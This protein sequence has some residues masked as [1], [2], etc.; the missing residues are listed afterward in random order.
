[1]VA[2]LDQ[3]LRVLHACQLKGVSRH[4]DLH[5]GNVLVGEKDDADLD[6]SLHPREPIFVS[7]FGYGATGGKKPKDDYVGLADIVDSLFEKV[8]WD[9]ATTTDRQMIDG[10]RKLMDKLLRE[11]SHSERRSPLEILSSIKDLKDRVR[12]FGDAISFKEGG[13]GTT[14]PLSKMSVGQFQVSEMLGDDWEWWKKLFVSAVPA[15]SRI[16]EPYT[17]TV[18]T[19]PRGCGKTMLFRRLSARLMVECGPIDSGTVDSNF[20]GLY[21]NANDIADAFATFPDK[22]GRKSSEKLICYANLCIL[23]DVLAVQSARA[24][25]FGEKASEGLLEFLRECFFDAGASS[26]LIVGEDPLEHYRLRLEQIKW[27]FPKTTNALN[28]VGFDDLSRHVWFARF[29]AQARH[30][31]PWIGLRT[32]FLFIDDYTTPRITE[33]MQRVLN[34]MIF[35]RSSEFVSKV[36]TESATTFVPEDSSGKVLQDGDDYQLIDMG[37]EA[38]FMAEQERGWFLNEVFRRRLALDT[39]IPTPDPDLNGLLGN[40][41]F[42]KTEFAR[43]LREP[44]D[45]FSTLANAD[46]VTGQVTSRRRGA[47][48]ARAL[49]HGVEVFTCLWSGD[50]RTMIQLIQELVDDSTAKTDTHARIPIDSERQDAIFRNRGGQWLE[51]QTRNQPSDPD[52]V[53]AYLRQVRTVDPAFALTG[54]TYGRHLKAVVEAFVKAARHLLLGPMYELYEGPGVREVPRMAFRIEVV[55]EF[56]VEGLAAE[57]YKDLIRYGIFMRDAR[58]KSVRGAFVPRLYLRRLLLPFCTLALSK[59]DSVPMTCDWFNRL[60]LL[61]DDFKDAFIKHLDRN[62]GEN[63]GY[64]Q[65]SLLGAKTDIISW[66]PPDPRYNDLDKED[67]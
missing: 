14:Q 45:S 32:I 52:A 29:V 63:A 54:G 27:R 64:V 57:I 23:S 61:P 4:G 12:S 41:L 7:D 46:P 59:R 38:L 6:T 26:P 48:K 3:I 53:E 42:R 37:E 55:D 36:A 9:K 22:P 8:E 47:A 1:V 2:V 58:G 39:R 30:F 15:R 35:H 25:G 5:A 21:V 24:V 67:L 28:F 31:C 62:I 40:A 11:E 34:R 13:S 17:P 19:G 10:I 33:P 66:D 51:A 20:V 49:Y 16:L 44:R 43:R 18:V 50:T 56:R 60:L 65:L